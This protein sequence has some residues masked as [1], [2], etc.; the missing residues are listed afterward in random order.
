MNKLLDLV[1]FDREQIVGA[2]C[3]GHSISEIVRQLGFSWSTV[4]KVYQGYMDSG[5][6]SSDRANCK[7]QLAFTVHCERRLRRIVHSQRS[8]ALAQITLQLNVGAGRTVNKRTA[9]RSLNLMGFGGAVDLR[10]YHCSMLAI[11]LHV[12]PGQKSTETGV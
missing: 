2:R 8:Q 6:K 12:L 7:G 11:S 9:Q 1:A 4:S 5:Q 3:M 10:E